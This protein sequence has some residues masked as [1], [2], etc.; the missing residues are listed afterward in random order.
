MLEGVPADG[1]EAELIVCETCGSAEQETHGSTRGERLLVQ[2]TEAVRA[3]QANP[4][5]AISST[6]CLWACTR[7]CAVHLRSPRRVGYVI[8][9]LEPTEEHAHALLEYAAQYVAT[10]DGAVPLKVRPAALRGRFVCR[11]PN[12]ANPDAIKRRI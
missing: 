3:G 6:R 11:I 7:S 2:L 8:G 5:I 1:P 4:P 10:P 12:D 9:T